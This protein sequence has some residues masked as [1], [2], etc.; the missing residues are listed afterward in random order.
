MRRLAVGLLA[1]AL[2]IPGTPA[3][4]AV[5]APPV[6]LVVGLRTDNAGVLEHLDGASPLGGAAI[7]VEVPA[8]RLTAVT[9]TLRADPAV[10]YVEVDHVAQAA[11]ITPNDP[12]FANQWGIAKT[13]VTRA[14]S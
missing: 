14:W 3:F 4:A 11:A 9:A 1:G 8:N 10:R 12:E 5:A 7:S 6:A 2:L 13:G